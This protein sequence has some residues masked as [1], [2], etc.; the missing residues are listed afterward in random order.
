MHITNK[1]NFDFDVSEP[2]KVGNIAIFGLSPT[3][4][5]K[6]EYLSLSDALTNNQAAVS[7]VSVLGS[8]SS[9]LV[10]NY[11]NQNLLLVEG[12]L[13]VNSYHVKLLQDRVLNTTLVIAP[14]KSAYVP[15]SCV[16]KSRWHYSS[17][18]SY[19]FSVNDD[20]YFPQG[21]MRKNQDV[22]Y[23]SRDYGYKFADQVTVW[24]TID[25][26]IE[27]INA[28]SYT[29][30]INT[31]YER[32]RIEIE[33]NVKKFKAEFSDCGIIYGIG[34]RLIGLDIFN[35]NSIFRQFLPKLIRAI[36]ME[37]Y[38]YAKTL[39]SLQKKDAG[40]FLKLIQQAYFEEHNSIG[41]EGIEYR[42]NHP[43]FIAQGLFDPKYKSV[44]HFS[45]FMKEKEPQAERMIA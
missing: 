40:G 43:L 6:R 3:A 36:C 17:P 29:S 42:S 11:S 32:K 18:R 8:V 7:E 4:E 30:S 10:K 45:A 33:E 39:S 20:F 31:I 37:S 9:L 44:I 15:V 38:D 26:K 34:S 21:R 16:E 1:F 35:S 24:E 19:R 41:K 25:E 28:Y 14:F 13:F 12:E 2:K 27:K 22:Y 5:T 23:S